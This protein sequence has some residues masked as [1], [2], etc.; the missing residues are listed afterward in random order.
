M[1]T[2]PVVRANVAR[3]SSF[4]EFAGSTAAAI[5]AGRQ[6]SRRAQHE[7]AQAHVSRLAVGA[8]TAY[9]AALPLLRP[10]GPFNTSPVD[11]AGVILIAAVVPAWLAGR[12]ALPARDTPIGAC[13]AYL[14]R[15]FSDIHRMSCAR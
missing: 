7:R 10:S 13:I 2:Q 15:P 5:P 11:V 9:V 14:T 3:A 8:A 6:S 12:F 1:L 4:G